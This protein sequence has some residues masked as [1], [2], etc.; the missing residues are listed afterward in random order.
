MR[1]DELPPV[2]V[3]RRAGDSGGGRG[4]QRRPGNVAGAAADSVRPRRAATVRRHVR[5]RPCCSRQL[6]RSVMLINVQIN[7]QEGDEVP[8]ATPTEILEK[9]GGDPSRDTI[10]VSVSAS[11]T[12]PPA[13]VTPL[14][15]GT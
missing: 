3:P 9:L 5:D 14:P 8:T 15:V 4:R 11:H 12:P 10:S 7:L 1:T 13:E 6:G 2:Q